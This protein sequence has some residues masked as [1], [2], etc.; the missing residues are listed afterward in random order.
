MS[1][2]ENKSKYNDLLI[3]AVI[4][5]IAL[6]FISLCFNDSMWGDE[7]YS[8]LMIEHG[9]LGIAETTALD[10]HP[11]LYYYIAKIFAMIFGY[12]VTVVKLVS[13]LPVVLTMIF[14]WMKSKKLFP[15]YYT[16]LSLVF[17][18]L[19]GLNPQAF[20]YNIQLRMYTWAMFFVT[21]SGIFAYELFRELRIK[22]IILF[23]LVSLGAAYTHYYAAV[24][25]CFVYFMLFVAILLKN[26]KNMIYC[27]AITIFTI[28][29]YVPWLPFFYKQLTTTT[30]NWWLATLKWSNLSNS[31]KFLFD[32]DFVY[33]YLVIAGAVVIGLCK[34]LV[35]LEKKE[36]C[37]YAI[38][39]IGVCVLT[40][41]SGY[42]ISKLVR[43]L[44]LDRYIYPSAGLLFLGIS[45]ALCCI[46]YGKI[47]RE[48]L[49][50]IVC[51][52]VPFL[53]LTTL[54]AE[55]RTGTDSAIQYIQSNISSDEV[56]STDHPVN[57]S[58][59]PWY[60]PEYQCNTVTIDGNTSGYVLTQKTKKELKSLIP[61]KKIKTLYSGN[62]D[63]YYYFSIYY[64]E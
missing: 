7:A 48:I 47:Y 43:P 40:I 21:C 64:V 32:G 23:I 60:L 63:N 35:K 55:Y 46:D 34:S 4:I 10:V 49:I 19:I 62:V 38:L 18:L 16:K 13:V 1:Y 29:G 15:H 61:N 44:F 6:L 41:F 2:S 17:I 3:L 42:V 58:C 12:R 53:Y 52:E 31:I 50:A 56:I 37:I 36:V 11:P 28:I 54:Q 24:A 14:V 8:M 59:L 26:K 9:F 45:I 57:W 39:C 51:V 22:T 30:S 27:I 25:E 33:F 5:L 20:T